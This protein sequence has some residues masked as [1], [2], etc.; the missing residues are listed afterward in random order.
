[1]YLISQLLN[2]L[3]TYFFFC[4]PFNYSPLPFLYLLSLPLFTTSF[5]YLFIVFYSAAVFGKL[6]H[7]LSETKIT[8]ES[9]RFVKINQ[10]VRETVCCIVLCHVILCCVMSYCILYYS[11]FLHH[12]LHLIHPF[13]LPLSLFP[14]S[15]T[16]HHSYPPFVFYHYPLPPLTTTLYLHSPLPSTFTHHYPLP[17]PLHPT[18]C[19]ALYCTVRIDRGSVREADSP[20]KRLKER[21]RDR[22]RERER[23]RDRSSISP[24]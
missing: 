6:P 15:P 20:T 4:L 17:P 5:L 12:S 7:L 10:Q 18:S 11:P 14:L 8:V 21:E 16:T 1:M 13:P 3:Y 9:S 22:E 24:R 2:L 19:T 23:E